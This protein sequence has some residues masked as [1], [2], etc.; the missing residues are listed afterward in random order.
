MTDAINPEHYKD[1]P[2][3]S[4]IHGEC[5]D[6]SER[7]GFLLGN[8]FKYVWRA[9]RKGDLREDL[10]KALWYLD[11][12]ERTAAYYSQA[13]LI[14]DG[15]VPQTPRRRILHNIAMSTPVTTREATRLIHAA[16][17]RE[18]LLKTID[19]AVR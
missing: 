3:N 4:G 11:R 13:P 6:Y 16:V 10:R 17:D 12:A 14:V 1:T 8:A 15:A 19:G 5:I 9:G 2:P 7:I 18:E